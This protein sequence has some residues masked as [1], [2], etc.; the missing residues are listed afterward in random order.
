MQP[1]IFR[2]YCKSICGEVE[3]ICRVKGA[4]A[5]DTFVR[6]EICETTEN[7]SANFALINEVTLFRQQFS[8]LFDREKKLI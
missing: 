7:V 3:M 5:V 2:T 8:Q 4:S 6:D 1:L